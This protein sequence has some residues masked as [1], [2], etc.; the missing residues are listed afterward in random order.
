MALKVN[1]SMKSHN[2]ENARTTYEDGSSVCSTTFQSDYKFVLLKFKVGFSVI[3]TK[4][5]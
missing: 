1:N 3:I 4:H 2:A 5:F